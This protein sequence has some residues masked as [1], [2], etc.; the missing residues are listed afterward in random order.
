[1]KDTIK[2]SQYFSQ[3]S[4]GRKIAGV[5]RRTII[6]VPDL[7]AFPTNTVVNSRS[8]KISDENGPKFR[9]PCTLNSK[10]MCNPDNLNF[11]KFGAIVIELVR[12]ISFVLYGFKT[13]GK[14]RI[15]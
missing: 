8:H 11:R 9:A 1:M 7:F 15:V 5:L 13:F 6:A 4:S 3:C 10:I 12:F 14:A 2:C